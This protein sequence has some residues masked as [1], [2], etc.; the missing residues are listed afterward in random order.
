MMD[1]VLVTNFN[2]IKLGLMKIR[3]EEHKKIS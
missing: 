3:V 2:R 1:D